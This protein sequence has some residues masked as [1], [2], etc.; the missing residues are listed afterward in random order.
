FHAR[1]S[2]ESSLVVF[3]MGGTTAKTSFVDHGHALTTNEFEVARTH[4]LQRGSGLPLRAPVIDMIEVGAGGGS[5]AGVNRLG[6]VTVGPES[7]GASPGPACYGLGGTNAT[8]TDADLLLGYLS[9]ERFLG[10]QMPLQPDAAADAI[11][12]AVAGPLGVE[13]TDAAWAIHRV[14]NESMAA[15]VR[16]HSV[17]RGKSLEGYSLFALGGAGPMHACHVAEILRA[18]RVV[19]P[20][21]AGVASAFGFLCSPASFESV[22][23]YYEQLDGVD[24]RRVEELLTDMRREGLQLL[25]DAGCAED[26]VHVDYLC[27]LRYRGQAYEMT[28]PLPRDFLQQPYREVLGA[29]RKSYTDLFRETP[30]T[31]V[32]CLNWRISLAG[33]DPRVPQSEI[34]PGAHPDPLEHRQAYFPDHGGYVSTAVFRRADL[35]AGSLI[36]GPAVVEED[37]STFVLPPAFDL[38]IDAAGNLT[39]TRR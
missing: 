15:A 1:Q 7:A 18:R 2:T 19:S 4:R 13:V 33:P 22:R 31:P 6:L 29:F 21:G 11:Q 20:A 34:P 36:K 9:H 3:D 27:D 10:G 26:D 38:E 16:V 23:S 25:K 37:E 5:I 28:V 32:E 17:E 24:W 35:G 30:A 14:V 12:K 39:A 8:V